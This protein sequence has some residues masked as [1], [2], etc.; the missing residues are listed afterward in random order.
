MTRGPRKPPR[1][2]PRARSEAAL[3]VA[4]ALL[5]ARR[6]EAPDEIDVE[7]LASSCGVSLL[8]GDLANEEG[9]LVHRGDRAV[10]RVA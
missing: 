2:T 7:A 3:A 10:A 8:W 6:I 5:D 4:R 9:H 1:R